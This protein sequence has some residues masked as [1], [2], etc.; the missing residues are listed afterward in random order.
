MKSPFIFNSVAADNA[1]LESYLLYPHSDVGARLDAT[2]QHQEQA[3]Q[4]DGRASAEE[5]AHG[6]LSGGHGR[7]ERKVC[8]LK[9]ERDGAASR[10]E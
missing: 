5:D 2:S 8:L 9:W 1:L 3:D 6:P 10:D 4:Q 7:R